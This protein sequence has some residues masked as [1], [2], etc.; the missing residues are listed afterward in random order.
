MPARPHSFV[1]A[2]EATAIVARFEALRTGPEA[3]TYQASLAQVGAEF[4]RGPAT[5]SRVVR[6]HREGRPPGPKTPPPRKKKVRL[7]REHLD[8]VLAWIRETPEIT[9]Y[10]LTLRLKA[11]RGIEIQERT[12]QRALADEGLTKRRYAK[13]VA[14]ERPVGERKKVRVGFTEAHRRV[15]RPK[16]HR[17]GY[18]SDLTDEEWDILRPQLAAKGVFDGKKFLLRDIVDGILYQ[19]RTGCAYAYMPNDLPPGPV[20]MNRITRWS[21]SGLLQQIHDALR[22]VVRE[23]Q[24]RSVEPTA[25]IIDSQTTKSR[26]VSAEV[27]YD[28]A[29]KTKGRKRHIVADT[30]GLILALVVHSAGV[31]DRDGARLIVNERLAEQYSKLEVIFTDSG[32]QGRF[33]RWANENLPFKVEVVHRRGASSAGAWTERGSEPPPAVKEFKVL[34][35]RWI[36]ERTF[37]W[38]SRWNRLSQDREVLVANSEGRVWLAATARMLGL[39]ART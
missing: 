19:T 15:A 36:I 1:R 14:V 20:I 21:R 10:Q 26:G 17:R 31:Q 27:G 25:G 37:G 23:A 2:D 34:P 39:L 30:L 28:G 5:V 7:A 16:P 29:K 32:Y 22:G 33:E 24:G 35:K 12:L 9:T 3:L 8:A 38:L 18:P 6:A 4:G 13:A 11:E